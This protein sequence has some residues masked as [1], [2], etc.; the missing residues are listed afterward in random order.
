[1]RMGI[2]H[3]TAKGSTDNAKGP[4]DRTLLHTA[5][6]YGHK[7]VTELLIFKG[8]DVNTKDNQGLTPLWYAKER[9]HEQT[10]DLLRK[11]G[12]KE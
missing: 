1:M 5:A 6:R 8:A 11:H 12:A 10:V 7:A 2:R 3:C 9:G 4:R